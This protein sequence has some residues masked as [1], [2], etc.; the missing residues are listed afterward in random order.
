MHALLDSKFKKIHIGLGC[1]VKNAC[2][3]TYAGPCRRIFDFKEFDNVHKK[4]RNVIE[5]TLKREHKCCNIYFFQIQANKFWV[6][7]GVLI[8]CYR[9]NQFKLIFKAIARKQIIFVLKDMIH[10]VLRR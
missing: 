3:E 10:P 7:N 4:F 1:R 6:M 8:L 2:P 9:K 5:I